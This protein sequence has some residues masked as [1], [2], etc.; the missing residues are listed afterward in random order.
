MLSRQSARVAKQRTRA[1]LMFLG[2][3]NELLWAHGGRIVGFIYIYAEISVFYCKR[4]DVWLETA[5][6]V[7]L[8]S[9]CLL[10]FRAEGPRVINMVSLFWGGEK[11]KPEK[12][13]FGF[14]KAKRCQNYRK[15]KSLMGRIAGG[16]SD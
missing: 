14:D 12:F 5:K 13:E 11:G 7:Q 4:V 16:G 8:L 10:A 9:G 3:K 15:L 6:K 2:I 1:R